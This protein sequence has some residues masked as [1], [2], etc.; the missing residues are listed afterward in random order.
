[1]LIY[2][3]LCSSAPSPN[4]RRYLGRPAAPRLDRPGREHEGG[5]G[6]RSDRK[7]RSH[8]AVDITPKSKNRVIKYHIGQKPVSQA[9]RQCN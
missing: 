2:K 9:T 6:E 7:E 8:G 3:I 4:P 1:M 5:I